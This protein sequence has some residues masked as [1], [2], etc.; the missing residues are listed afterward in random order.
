MQDF[1]FEIPEDMLGMTLPGKEVVQAGRYKV[2][3]PGHGQ[4]LL[5]IKSGGICGSDLKYIYYTHNGTGGAR[6]DNVIAGHEPCGQIVK[7]GQGTGDFAV[8]DR[9][10]VYHIQGCGLCEECRKGFMNAGLMAGKGTVLL[11][12]IC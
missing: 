7:L 4:V 1:K 11:P 2:P 12:S 3:E 8:G 10:V 9:V 6:Y 5:K